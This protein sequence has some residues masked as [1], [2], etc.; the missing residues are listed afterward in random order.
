MSSFG[1]RV[2]KPVRLIRGLRQVHGCVS[3]GL[4]KTVGI[5]VQ[6]K[7]PDKLVWALLITKPFKPA[8]CKFSINMEITF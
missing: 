3:V 1:S 7:N 5:F 2:L 8:S 6:C 4:S